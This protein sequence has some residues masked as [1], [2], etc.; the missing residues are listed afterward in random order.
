[1]TRSQHA[2][3][4][5]AI[6][7][8]IPLALAYGA[9]P[10]A[11]ATARYLSGHSGGVSTIMPWLLLACAGTVLAIIRPTPGAPRKRG[12]LT[13]LILFALVLAGLVM[14]QPDITFALSPY[15][16]RIIEISPLIM[17]LFCLLWASTCGLPDRNDFQRFGALLGVI[18]IIDLAAELY[19]YH[20][21]PTVRWI[22]NADFLAG[23]LLIPI[24]AGLKPGENEGGI[25]EPDQ[26]KSLWRLLALLGLLSCMSRT[27]FFGAGWVVL[28]FGRSRLS[29]RILFSLLCA[30]LLVLTFFLPTTASDA[31]RYTDYWLWM[32]TI[33]MFSEQPSMMLTGFPLEAPLPIRFPMGMEAIWEAA[34]GSSS[35]IGVYL[36]QVPSFWLRLSLGWGI[37]VPLGLM[38]IVFL[39]LFRRLTRMGAGLVAALFAQGMSTSLL[40][41]PAMAVPIGLS[42]ILALSDPGIPINVKKAH[43]STPSETTPEDS[44]DPT[45]EWDFRPL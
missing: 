32:E 7:A 41:N 20:A 14:Y 13:N 36:A 5:S 2:Q 1:M 26:G 22:G 34:T 12:I 27:G 33:R 3:S 44:S 8:A 31:I 42:F 43:E 45:E 28:C 4:G 6:L 37:A 30:T 29:M 16:S 40:F 10:L 15:L 17:I 24:C 35:V 11:T 25:N 39:L 19:L 23:L 38:G 9:V 21:V 18:C